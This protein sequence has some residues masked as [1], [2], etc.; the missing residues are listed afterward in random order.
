MRDYIAWWRHGTAQRLTDGRSMN[1][2]APS[3]SSDPI[4]DRTYPS[5]IITAQPVVSVI[6]PLITDEA[7]LEIARSTFALAPHTAGMPELNYQPCSGMLLDYFYS[8]EWAGLAPNNRCGCSEHHCDICNRI[9][10][11]ENQATQI[12]ALIAENM[13]MCGLTDLIEYDGEIETTIHWHNVVVYQL[14]AH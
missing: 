7:L 12:V 5:R 6:S 2:A 1:W 14:P 4:G 8:S 11:W 10:A 9:T 13:S 3:S